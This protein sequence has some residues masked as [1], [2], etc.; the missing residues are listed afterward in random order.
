MTDSRETTTTDSDEWF[1]IHDWFK[2]KDWKNYPRQG[3]YRRD[4]I[5]PFKSYDDAHQYLLC[6]MMARQRRPFIVKG[7]DIPVNR[8]YGPEVYMDD[9]IFDDD[10]AEAT[11]S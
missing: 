5:G 9:A 2:P 6:D 4:I 10:D 7:K 3:T 1:V 11:L 8:T